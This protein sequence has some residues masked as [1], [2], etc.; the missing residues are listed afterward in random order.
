MRR[1]AR[2]IDLIKARQDIETVICQADSCRCRLRGYRPVSYAVSTG[3]DGR[4][5]AIQVF[6]RIGVGDD[7]VKVPVIPPELCR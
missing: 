3:G 1:S 7:A 5:P 4:R 6:A 2:A